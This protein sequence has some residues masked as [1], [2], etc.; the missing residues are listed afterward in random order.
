MDTNS[1]TNTNERTNTE[2]LYLSRWGPAARRRPPSQS[3]PIPALMSNFGVE[4][5]AASMREGLEAKLLD[6]RLESLLTSVTATMI[7][8]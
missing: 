5:E 1:N 7:T 4:G 2:T 6:P 3:S 8:R